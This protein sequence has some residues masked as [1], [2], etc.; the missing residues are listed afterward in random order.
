MADSRLCFVITTDDPEE[1]AVVFARSSIEAKRDWANEHLGRGEPLGG[2][3]AR[4]APRWDRYVGKGVP[5]L[6]LIEDG[7]WFE[8]QGCG[9][10]ICDEYVGTR[11]RENRGYEDY[12]LDKEYG[13]D[14][15]IPRMEPIDGTANRV[16]CCQQ[17][18]DEDFAER[19]LLKRYGERVKAWLVRGL[20][21][22]FPEVCPCEGLSQSYSYPRSHVYVAR[23]N[24]RL[25]VEQVIVHFAWPT[26]KI[27][28]GT[29]RIDQQWHYGK[30]K[31]GRRNPRRAELLVAGGD[32]AAFESWI[33][34]QRGERA[35]A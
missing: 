1:S 25:V 26:A 27:G 19:A 13:A 2:I 17:C 24:G 32:K 12:L 34:E 3:S 14:L 7:W 23:R 15:S 5:A 33:A 35:A 6:E 4:R 21:D 22:K 30:D 8:C 10:K 9:T 11:D 28:L 16:W 31:F 29:Y 20:G 18:H